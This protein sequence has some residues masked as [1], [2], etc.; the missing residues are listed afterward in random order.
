MLDVMSRWSHLCLTSTPVPICLGTSSSFLGRCSQAVGSVPLVF[1]VGR[2]I[3]S[4]LRCAL[5]STQ[6][7]GS[8]NQL[9][10]TDDNKCQE[11]STS[12]YL[13]PSTEKMA[14]AYKH[15][16]ALPK[17]QVHFEHIGGFHGLLP[18]LV[19]GLKTP[20]FSHRIQWPL[21]ICGLSLCSNVQLH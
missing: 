6:T 9:V 8:S 1:K 20:L 11:R 17:I 18:T 5:S 2:A 21:R 10:T 16:H 15:R 7:K 12:V 14:Q 19:F 4:N 3:G 13:S